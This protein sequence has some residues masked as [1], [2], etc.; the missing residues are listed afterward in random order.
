MDTTAHAQRNI[1]FLMWTE[2]RPMNTMGSAWKHSTITFKME[3]ESEKYGFSRRV[4]A[5]HSMS[6]MNV[7]DMA[8]DAANTEDEET[9]AADTRKTH[10][11]SVSKEYGN[12][13]VTC[14]GQVWNSKIKL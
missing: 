7:A 3:R 6:W 4:S 9:E 8:E 5:R 11:S 14:D 1:T 2:T 13:D 12:K 10:S